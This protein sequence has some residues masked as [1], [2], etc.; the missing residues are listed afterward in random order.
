MNLNKNK[1]F[2]FLLGITSSL[3][4]QQVKKDSL[5]EVVITAT[6]T[7]RQLVSLPIPITLVNKETIKKS[8]SLRLNEI[9]EEQTGIVTVPDQSGF[10]GI[11]IQG[12]ESEYILILIDGVPLLRGRTSGNFDLRQLA[13]GNIKQVEVVK[14]PSSALYGS[15]ALGGVI[16]IITE[17]PTSKKP[18][19]FL[20][21]RNG[22][23]NEQDINLNI[24]QHLGKV[25]YSLY[26]NRFSSKGYDLTN[27]DDFATVTPFENYT[28]GGKFIYKFSNALKN[29]TSVRAFTEF[30][31]IRTLFEGSSLLGNSKSKDYNIH[32][33]TQHHWNDRFDTEYE[34]YFTQLRANETINGD[35]V[36]Q[37]LF[38]TDFNNK[39]FRPEIR[40]YY[41]PSDIITFTF[42]VGTTLDFLD[43][44]SIRTSQNFNSQYVY[45]QG[46]FLIS[47]RLNIIL[48]ARQD[49]HSE[50]DKRFSPKASLRFNI[51]KY[52]ALKGSVGTAFKAPAFRQLF[53]D[54]T[55]SSVGYTVLGRNVAAN[56]LRAFEQ[57][58]D[59]ARLNETFSNLE[60]PLK[61]ET[62]TAFNMGISHN[63]KSLKIDIN[64]FYNDVKNLIDTYAIAQKRSNAQNIFSYKNFGNIITHGIEVSA[65]TTPIK[66]LNISGGYQLLYH[67]DKKV[68]NGFENGEDFFAKNSVTRESFRIKREDYYGLINRSKHN[69]NIKLFYDWEKVKTNF[70]FRTLYRSRYGLFDQNGNGILDNFDQGSAFVKGFAISNITATKKIKDHIEVQIGANNLFDV[71]NNQQNNLVGR[72][73]Y[74][75]LTYYF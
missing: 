8:G 70:S 23:F 16:N 50:Y 42:G 65:S 51:D 28:F 2:I 19:G 24:G 45:A 49:W 13:L 36:E 53:L 48:G 5:S 21:Y 35:T 68:V 73:V 61:A 33:L 58:D 10:E 14:G 20:S 29:I 67:F 52:W 75:K 59:I 47:K 22:T 34:L 27:D 40:A 43:R 32:N 55:N 71:K 39:L 7:Q 30:Q 6:R 1:I 17:T 15:E 46:D 4:G 12:L 66:N 72:R 62:S 25:V 38:N 9:L 41:R 69:I 54:F 11:Q 64:Y 60:T 3:L 44:S 57:A 74:G 37:S 26:T 56:R 63:S 18:D 31:D